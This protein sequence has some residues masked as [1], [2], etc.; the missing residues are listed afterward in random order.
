MGFSQQGYWRGLPFPSPGD[1]PGPGIEPGSPTVQAD[2]L[3]S[4]PPGKP[5]E[6]LIV[7][8]QLNV[9]RYI[10]SPLPAIFPTEILT[11]L[12]KFKTLPFSL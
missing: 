10:A 11:R 7:I 8:N 9:M 5:Y 2:S 6:S 1:I 12:Y 4:E 3:L